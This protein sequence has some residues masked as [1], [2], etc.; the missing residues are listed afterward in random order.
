M[1]VNTKDDFECLPGAADGITEVSWSP[2]LDYLAVSSW[3][4]QVHIVLVTLQTRI[5]EII[6]ATKTAVPKASISHEGPSFSCSWS[7]DGSKIAS[8]GADKTVRIL[9][10]A[11]GGQQLTVPNAHE[12]PIRC[13][14]WAM[15]SGMAVL[16]TGGWDKQVKYWAVQTA[17][18]PQ[19]MGALSVPERVFAMDVCSAGGGLLVIGT[20]ERHQIIVSLQQNPLQP[21]TPP[22]ASPLKMQTRTIA[23]FPDGQGYAIGSVEGRV[24]LQYPF[25]PA[26][27]FAFKCHREGNTAYS[28]NSI[29]FHPHIS[30]VFATAGTDGI[31]NL[32][33][34]DSKQRLDSFPSVN[35]PIN[36]IAF[37]RDGSLLA[38][39]VSYDWSRGHEHY[40]AGG[41]N[42]VYIHR[43]TDE[44]KPRSGSSTFRRR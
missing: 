12:Q 42:A 1:T 23:C 15:I 19:L 2:I 35:M 29:A 8:V 28:V 43:V 11:A 16:I 36:S 38:L 34:K 40:Q 39:A 5:Y 22:A 4:G 3:D 25:T 44:V 7:P 30:S 24:G 27:H 33:D 17:Q 6:S 32:W 21:A 41:K 14:R 18:S 31:I 20:A 37:N 10:M 13:C 26:N 9:D